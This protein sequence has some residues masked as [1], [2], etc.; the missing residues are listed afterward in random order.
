MSSHTFSHN[1]IKER[2]SQVVTRRSSATTITQQAF[3]NHIGEAT[4][5]DL[6]QSKGEA[7]SFHQ[8]GSCVYA[9]I[10]NIDFIFSE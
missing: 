4:Y 1:D 5:N 8:S 9:S 10:Q 6:I 2:A 7:E 3:I